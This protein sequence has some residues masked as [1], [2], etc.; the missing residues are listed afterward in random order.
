MFQRHFVV[1]QHMSYREE[2]APR[3]YLALCQ[4]FRE[5]SI[6]RN[7]HSQRFESVCPWSSSALSAMTP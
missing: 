4:L 1:A 2:A 5:V 6:E 7:P 3:N